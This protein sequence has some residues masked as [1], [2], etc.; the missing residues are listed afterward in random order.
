MELREAIQLGF[1]SMEYNIAVN[2]SNTYGYVR[3]PSVNMLMQMLGIDYNGA[4]RIRYLMEILNGR[5]D[6]SINDIRDMGDIKCVAKHF[7]KINPT[8]I[9][10]STEMLLPT[11]VNNIP[12][13][14]VVMGIRDKEFFNVNS[15]NPNDK[16]GYYLVESVGQ[17]NMTLRMHK[18]VNTGKRVDGDG[19]VTIL[20]IDTHG[21]TLIRVKTSNVRVCNRY[22]VV[23]SIRQPSRHSGMYVMV[24]ISGDLL[25]VYART[26]EGNRYLGKNFS[27]RVYD[28]GVIPRELNSRLKS[29]AVDAY[30]GL[31]CVCVKYIEPT[32]EFELIMNNS[33]SQQLI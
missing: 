4:S 5:K 11:K 8:C 3:V 1:N 28:F 13:L 15:K 12:K 31:H 25:Y 20:G 21:N 26:V 2:I 10:L 6:I 16:L 29:V 9:K 17:N 33:Q 7:R 18:R 23:A 27:E 30:N 32:E 24:T 22:I 19:I 14:A